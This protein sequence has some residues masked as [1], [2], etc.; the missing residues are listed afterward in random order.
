[1]EIV[2]PHGEGPQAPLRAP[3]GAGYLLLAGN[4]DRRLPFLPPSRAKRALMN[5]VS[6]ELRELAELGS[7]RYA[8]LLVARLVAP[9]AGEQLLRRRGITQARFDVVVLIKTV[10]PESAV[11]LRM[12]PAYRRLHAHMSDG[13][14]DVFE[15]AARNVRRIADVEHTRSSVYL[16]NYFYADDAQRLVPVWEYTAGWFVENTALPDSE[17][18]EPL[19]QE[20]SDYGIVN[21]ASWPHWHTF[22]PKLIFLPSFRRFV[23]GTFAANDIA[24]QPIMYRLAARHDGHDVGREA[25]RSARPAAESDR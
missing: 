6:E 18:L 24:A 12:H 3:S 1:M 21:H 19:A 13:A 9:G 2:L 4:V 20:R 8:D 25:G 23:L 15:I 11:D 10:D 14:R 22:L 17:V 5:A 16:F 7:V